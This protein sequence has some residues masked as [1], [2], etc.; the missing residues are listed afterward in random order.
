M[1]REK[2]RT[3]NQSFDRR[4]HRLQNRLPQ[5]LPG[6]IVKRVLQTFAEDPELCKQ[7]ADII[8]S[9]VKGANDG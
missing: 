8:R 5:P 4:L 1:I 7:F 6:K 9:G 2:S 3:S